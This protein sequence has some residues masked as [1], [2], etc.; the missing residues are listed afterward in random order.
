MTEVSVLQHTIY[1]E[2]WKK[3]AQ[4][5][6]P[7]SGMVVMEDMSLQRL[8]T[9]LKLLRRKGVITWKRLHNAREF[10]CLV[11]PE[12]LS[13]IKRNP[14]P[15]R[16]ENLHREHQLVD[17]GSFLKAVRKLKLKPFEDAP[18]LKATLSPYVGSRFRPEARV[19]AVVRASRAA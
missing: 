13:V 17:D 15:S 12:D 19:L 14:S 10:R 2:L 6:R 18:N 4:G 3:T 8:H 5:T 9:V 1:A 11:K 7:W 16:P